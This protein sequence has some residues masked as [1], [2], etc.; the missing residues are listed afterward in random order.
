MELSMGGNLL[1]SKGMVCT[2]KKTTGGTFK[3]NEMELVGALTLIL[4]GS[5]GLD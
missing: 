3:R 2:Q 1:R 4:F 5:C